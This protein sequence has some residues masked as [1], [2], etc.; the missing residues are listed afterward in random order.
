MAEYAQRHIAA[1]RERGRIINIS[2][3][4]ADGFAGEVSYGASQAALESYSR[5]AALALGPHGATVNI[6]ALGP[7]QA[8]WIPPD[9]EHA[10]AANTR[11]GRVGQPE[12]IADVVVFLASHQARWITGQRLFVRG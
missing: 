8:A 6:V 11:L 1:K 9:Q 4:G 7:I 3:E 12:D 5:A 10:V 2:T